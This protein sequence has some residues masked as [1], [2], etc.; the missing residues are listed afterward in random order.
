MKRIISI[1]ASIF[2]IS[3]STNA[4]VPTGTRQGKSSDTLLRR[5]VPKADKYDPKATKWP[6]KD[7][8]K[9]IETRRDSM[10]SRPIKRKKVINND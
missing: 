6:K 8:L 4:Q 2:F 3:F 7:S 1:F 10:K 5:T 9:R